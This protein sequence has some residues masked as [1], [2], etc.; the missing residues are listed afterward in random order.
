MSERLV[1]K[2]LPTFQAN[3]QYKYAYQVSDEG[4]QTYIAHEENRD[5][6]NVSGQYSY[7]DP[8]G[9]LITVRFVQFGPILTL[10]FNAIVIFL[11]FSCRF[12]II[13]LLQSISLIF[14]LL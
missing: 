14:S 10:S 6:E 13:P 11:C 3:P 9:S 1:E 12:T 4:F 2:Y 5:G 8:L 7:V